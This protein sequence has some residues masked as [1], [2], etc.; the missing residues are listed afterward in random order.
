MYLERLAKTIDNMENLKRE[1]DYSKAS[2]N[3]LLRLPNIN[4]V[5]EL[6]YGNNIFYMLNIGKD[7][8]IPIKY[9][10]RKNYEKLALSIWYKITRNDGFFFDIGAHTGI[11]TI[12]GNLNKQNNKIISLEPYYTNHS[13][14]ISNLKLNDIDPN[15][16]HLKAASNDN[17]IAKFSISTIPGYHTQGGKISSDGN[18]N[19]HKIKLDNFKLPE[20]VSG[21]KID[22]EGHEYEVLAGSNEIISTNKPDI[23]FEINPES[24]NKSVNFLKLQDYKFYFI[25]E[26]DEELNEVNSYSDN[27]KKEEGTNCLATLKDV[28]IFSNFDRFE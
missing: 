11:Y 22:T 21:I 16:C 23:L 8:S 9:F 15:L 28:N 17:G 7:D 26:D 4:G 19:I 14:L 10:W 5:S 20:K 12:I 18:V 1:N 27:L 3:E 6:E 2:L 24:F 25:N 13:R